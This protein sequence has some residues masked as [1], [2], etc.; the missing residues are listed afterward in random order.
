MQV[1]AGGVGFDGAGEWCDDEGAQMVV[2]LIGRDDD[3]GAGFL[4]L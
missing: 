4:N 1:D 3:A 2:H